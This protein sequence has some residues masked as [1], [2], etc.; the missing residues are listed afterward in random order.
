MA[1]RDLNG[2]G[3]RERVRIRHSEEPREKGNARMDQRGWRLGEAKTEIGE[4]DLLAYQKKS[5][6]KRKRP[7]LL[8]KPSHVSGKRVLKVKL[9]PGAV[10]F[11]GAGLNCAAS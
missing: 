8:G 7:P 9:K 1:E 3:R 6:G 4:K 10:A 2:E 11:G 5:Q